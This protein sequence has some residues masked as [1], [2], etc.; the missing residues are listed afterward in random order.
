[1][2]LWFA[3]SSIQRAMR[4]RK[5]YLHL[6]TTIRFNFFFY[7]LKSQ[8]CKWKGINFVAVSVGWF[9]FIVYIEKRSFMG[10]VGVQHM[11]TVEILCVGKKNKRKNETCTLRRLD[12]YTQ[13]ARATW[14]KCVSNHFLVDPIEIDSDGIFAV[15]LWLFVHAFNQLSV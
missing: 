10:R 11:W 2:F 14:Q 12:T 4:K 5:T 15:R 1:M 6:Q 3:L 7:P 13:N 9:A 8:V